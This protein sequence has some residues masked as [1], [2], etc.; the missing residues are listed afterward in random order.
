MLHTSLL[1]HLHRL[2]KRQLAL[3]QAG[4]YDR[5]YELAKFIKDYLKESDA[6]VMEEKPTKKIAKSWLN[7]KQQCELINQ[8]V[9]K[10]LNKEKQKIAKEYLSCE[11]DQQLDR[12]HAR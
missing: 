11:V 4:D 12:L 2:L 3:C 7:L 9:I 10:H 6:L 1:H 8:S 5:A